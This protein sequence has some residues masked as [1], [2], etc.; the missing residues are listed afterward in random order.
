M[1]DIWR[2]FKERMETVSKT[3]CA[4]V[5]TCR[6]QERHC[7]CNFFIFR[8]SKPCFFS[9]SNYLIILSDP[10]PKNGKI[11][12]PATFLLSIAIK[13]SYNSFTGLTSGPSPWA[14]INII[15]KPCS[16]WLEDPKTLKN[17]RIDP[18]SLKRLSIFY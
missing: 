2:Y 4:Q 14:Q 13:L 7:K 3:T 8:N 9:N 17:I 5:S 10:T 18:I 16:L 1:P 11:Y 12:L 15:L 6:D